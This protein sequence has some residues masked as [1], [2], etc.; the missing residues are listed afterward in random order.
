MLCDDGTEEECLRRN[1]FGDMARRFENLR[2][3][4]P[5]DAGFLLNINR[6]YV[7]S[8]VTGRGRGKTPPAINELSVNLD[9]D[10]WQHPLYHLLHFVFQ[11]LIRVHCFY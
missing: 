9:L 8:S 6:S 10:Q 3:I 4:E 5:G 2:E 1:L 7:I 11:C